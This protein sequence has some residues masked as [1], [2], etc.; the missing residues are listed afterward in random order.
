M[1]EL[2]EYSHFNGTHS[3]PSFANIDVTVEL[4]IS[5]NSTIYKYCD[6]SAWNNFFPAI[7][8][9]GGFQNIEWMTGEQKYYTDI[10]GWTGIALI[11]AITISVSYSLG[12]NL[13]RIRKVRKSIAQETFAFH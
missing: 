11:A 2:E 6:Q 4:Q 9:L 13:G 7:H 1:D 3:I 10:M 8:S 12:Y 5:S